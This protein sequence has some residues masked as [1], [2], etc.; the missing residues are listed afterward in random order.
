MKILCLYI[1][2][3]GHARKYLV[4]IEGKAKAIHE[5]KTHS[6]ELC[7]K[8]FTLK[9]NLKKHVE[10]VH[11]KV[12]FACEFCNETLSTRATLKRHVNSIH[13]K[14]NKINHVCETCKKAFSSNAYLKNHV[15]SI[16]ENNLIT[17]AVDYYVVETS[18]SSN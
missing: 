4:S 8:K 14:E 2:V 16:H 12:T 5:K 6:C 18:R 17:N 1:I 7:N 3:Q 10:A 15:K 9:G 13:K 11:E